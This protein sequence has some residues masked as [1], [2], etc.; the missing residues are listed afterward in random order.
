M[1]SKRVFDWSA[2]A[3]AENADNLSRS[4][5]GMRVKSAS[6]LDVAGSA[7]LVVCELM[8]GSCIRMSP[9][10]YWLFRQLQRGSSCEEIAAEIGCRFGQHVSVEDV[11]IACAQLV[12]R[13]RS[14]SQAV[15]A[16]MRRRYVFRVRLLPE[17]IVT[18]LAAHLTGL[19]SRPAVALWLCGVVSSAVL[20]WI[21]RP[22][23]LGI[24][25]FTLGASILVGFLIYVTALLAHE[26]GHATACARYGIRTGEIGFAVYLIFPAIYCDVTSAWL[27]PRRQRLVVDVAGIWFEI[28]MGAIFSTL[29]I[30]LHAASF[31]VAAFMV[32][33]NLV[34]VLNPL[35]RFDGYWVLSDALGIADLS[36]QRWLVLRRMFGK[37]DEPGQ[38][39]PR[40]YEGFHQA[41]VMSYSAV[42]VLV[43]GWFVYSAIGLSGPFAAQMK[44]SALM[45]SRDFKRGGVAAAA[46]ILV[47]ILPELIML[48]FALYRLM[49][50]TIP[51]LR[52][53]WRPKAIRVR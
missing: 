25:H 50:I 39:Y 7:E 14:E 6:R 19:L 27:L 11:E 51:F 16:A 20:F 32:L 17:R 44:L 47:S 2:K 43:V 9:S 10:A 48:A 1:L 15:A 4:D 5:E 24:E 28:G 40:S 42:T 33:G 12:D 18:R 36:R 31:G 30:I 53:L 46:E 35:G 41:I 22:S 52:K 29:G 8:N 13:V 38:A 37:R 49:Q 45:I 34:I 3:A 23:A 21:A 26:L